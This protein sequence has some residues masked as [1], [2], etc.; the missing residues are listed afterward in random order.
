MSLKKIVYILQTLLTE[1]SET[2]ETKE[3]IMNINLYRR[4]FHTRLFI[5]TFVI[6]GVDNGVFWF[7]EKR[8]WI[9]VFYFSETDRKIKVELFLL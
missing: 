7:L 3:I 9:L 5:M 8:F 2:L 1:L 4:M 6:C